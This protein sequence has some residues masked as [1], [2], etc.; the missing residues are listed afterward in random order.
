MNLKQ[1]ITDFHD[2]SVH[3]ETIPQSTQLRIHDRVFTSPTKR[4]LLAPL[5]L[6][7]GGLSLVVFGIFA[8]NNTT[9]NGSTLTHSLINGVTRT[10]TPTQ[11]LAESIDRTFNPQS[12]LNTLDFSTTEKITHLTL[13]T[14]RTYHDLKDASIKKTAQ[15]NVEIWGQNNASILKQHVVY[16]ENAQEG[17][18][19]KR[20]TIVNTDTNTICTDTSGSGKSAKPNSGHVCNAYST[21][22][23]AQNPFQAPDAS[24][25]ALTL[26]IDTSESSGPLLTIQSQH[27][28]VGHIML[29]DAALHDSRDV[30]IVLNE[31]LSD[32]L[33]VYTEHVELSSLLQNSTVR[34][35][36]TQFNTKTGYT[37]FYLINIEA[38]TV[39]PIAPADALI[40]T[41][42][43]QKMRALNYALAKNFSTTPLYTLSTH[44]DLFDQL[45]VIEEHS[46]INGNDTVRVRLPLDERSASGI[47]GSYLEEEKEAT[48]VDFWYDPMTLRIVQ[49][50]LYNDSG[51]EALRTTITIETIN[52]DPSAFFTVN[53]WESMLE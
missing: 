41:E 42:E 1:R 39:E 40:L 14:L 12:I 53:Q 48:S 37:G 3:Q 2:K 6:S 21:S 35:A 44:T 27:R 51:E 34:K 32:D 15:H 13:Q 43:L 16:T 10:L 5:S 18:T 31:G 49:F 24:A 46:T 20:S 25:E 8:W 17:K 4:S 22:S 38:S 52:E 9:Q 36:I 45:S 33:G 50:A 29:S 47:L 19:L 30:G 11:A 7:L 23:Y 28:L 26:S